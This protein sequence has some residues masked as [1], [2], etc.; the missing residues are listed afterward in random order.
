MKRTIIIL[1]LCSVFLNLKGQDLISIDQATANR[2][3]EQIM[4]LSSEM[5]AFEADF[6]EEKR[7]SVLTDIALSKGKMYYRRPNNI[8][9]EYIEPQQILLVA[10]DEGVLLINNGQQIREAN[11]IRGF[12]E[13][14][15]MI[16]GFIDGS[17]L[18]DKSMFGLSYF[19]D[20]DGAF[21]IRMVPKNRRMRQ[22]MEE[23]TLTFK[24]G[25]IHSFG[26]Q[27]SGDL[28]LIVFS[29]ILVNKPISDS[30]FS[31]DLYDK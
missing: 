16:K 3:I 22:F 26:M 1:S 20:S 31:L 28:T 7:V 25:L 19:E 2:R 17:A 15:N 30:I 11:A 18:N 14:S 23:L 5:I 10:V 8:R 24:D 13:I 21:V 12:L 29:N 6:V 4:N 27:Q 9:W